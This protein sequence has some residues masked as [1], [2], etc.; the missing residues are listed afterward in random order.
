VRPTGPHSHP[1]PHRAN[2][3][4][5]SHT[6]PADPDP[7]TTSHVLS[8]GAVSSLGEDFHVCA[9]SCHWGP[10]AAIV[11]NTAVYDK[12]MGNSGGAMGPPWGC[13][14]RRAACSKR[15]GY[16]LRWS[17]AR[18]DHATAAPVQAYSCPASLVFAAPTMLRLS[19]ACLQALHRQPLAHTPT[20]AV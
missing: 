1:R 7:F 8:A 12:W 5:D 10:V 6:T 9:A 15:A 18:P 20:A 3:V 11:R 4:A 16:R 14:R 17:A 19:L 13:S 2:G